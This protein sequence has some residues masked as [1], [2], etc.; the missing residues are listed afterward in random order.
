MSRSLRRCPR[1]LRGTSSRPSS[2]PDTGPVASRPCQSAGLHGDRGSLVPGDGTSRDS[3]IWRLSTSPFED[4]VTRCPDCG[5][6]NADHSFYCGKCSKELPRPAPVWG[7]VAQAPPGAAGP[8]MCVACGRSIPFEAWVCPYCG[9]DYSRQWRAPGQLEPLSDGMRIALYVLS[10]FVP[11]AGII[12]GILF[13]LKPDPEYKRVGK[14]CLIIGVL[15]HVIV[16]IVFAIVVFGMVVTSLS[17]L[18]L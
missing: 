8:R 15:C 14:I 7:P 18:P 3:H 1:R 11:L 17:V 9:H 4:M 6:E 10:V 16:P 5:W 12:I 13:I 2:G